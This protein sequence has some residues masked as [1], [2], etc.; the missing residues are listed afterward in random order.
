M[1][2]ARI[3]SQHEI[4]IFFLM[5]QQSMD[6]YYQQDGE[7]KIVFP[8][9]STFNNIKKYTLYPS[10]NALT[11]SMVSDKTL[12]VNVEITINF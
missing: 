5:V 10:L 8:E 7:T 2:K 9:M 1:P 4:D 12:F 6:C 3:V 11:D